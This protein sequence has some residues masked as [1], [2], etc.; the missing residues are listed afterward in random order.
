MEGT[1]LNIQHMEW[2]CIAKS[3]LGVC[4]KDFEEQNGQVWL[5]PLKLVSS[6]PELDGK[7]RIPFS[8]LLKFT[9]RSKKQDN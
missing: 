1:E 4:F 2:H 5:V 6:N 3:Q 8:K 7:C 9:E